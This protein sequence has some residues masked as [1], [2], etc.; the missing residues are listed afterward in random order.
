MKTI[1]ADR[2]RCVGGG[3]C[4]MSAPQLFAQGEDD[5]LVQ[6]IKPNPGVEDLD[7]AELAV[8]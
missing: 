3:N 2:T 5:G 7:A 8:I 1:V 6:V 4:V